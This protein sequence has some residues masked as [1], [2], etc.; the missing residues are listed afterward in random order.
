MPPALGAGCP[1]ADEV[2]VLPGDDAIN[3][4]TVPVT[5]DSTGYFETADGVS[6]SSMNYE[7]GER[8]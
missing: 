3:P 5:I 8:Q 2:R 7:S 1:T 4:F 6:V